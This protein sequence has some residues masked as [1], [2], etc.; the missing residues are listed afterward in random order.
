MHAP[1]SVSENRS[2]VRCRST[3][4][5]AASPGRMSRGVMDAIELMLSASYLLWIELILK[6]WLISN[7]QPR[8]P[9]VAS[10]ATSG[11][12]IAGFMALRRVHHPRL[13]RDVVLAW[14]TI[15]TTGS[16][17]E[18]LPQRLGVLPAVA[19]LTCGLAAPSL[20]MGREKIS[21][22]RRYFYGAALTIGLIALIN[23]PA[24][25]PEKIFRGGIVA[26]VT[27]STGAVAVWL[28]RG[29]DH[30]VCGPVMIPP[31]LVKAGAILLAGGIVLLFLIIMSPL[32]SLS[33]GETAW[34]GL[35][36]GWSDPSILQSGDIIGVISSPFHARRALI[37]MVCSLAIPLLVIRRE[38]VSGSRLALY[39]TAAVIGLAVF[40]SGPAKLLSR[41]M[42]DLLL[43]I[44]KSAQVTSPETLWY[45]LTLVKEQGLLVILVLGSTLITSLGA[46]VV[47]LT[48]SAERPELEARISLCAGAISSL[49]GVLL[50]AH[51]GPPFLTGDSVAGTWALAT[52]IASLGI[53]VRLPDQA[54]DERPLNNGSD[55]KR[56][57]W[58]VRGMVGIG[59]LG[60]ALAVSVVSCRH[61]LDQSI[62]PYVGAAAPPGYQTYVPLSSI[63]REM[64]DATVAFEDP[65]FYHHRGLEWTSLHYALRVNVRAGRVVLGGSTITQQLAKNLFLG[66][67]RTLWRKIKELAFAAEIERLL[68]KQRILELYLNTIDYGMGQHG[69]EAA[70]HYYF[71]KTPGQL[72]LAESAMLVGLVPRPPDQHLSPYQL[73]TGQRTALQRIAYRWPERY[74]EADVTGAAEAPLEPLV[75]LDEEQV[76]GQGTA[77]QPP[78]SERKNAQAYWRRMAV[79]IM[80]MVFV[81]CALTSA[82]AWRAF[83]SEWGGRPPGMPAPRRGRQKT[84]LLTCVAFLSALTIGA[85]HWQ[86][87]NR[88]RAE[89][90]IIYPYTA[91]P[92][93]DDR[94]RDATINCVVLHATAETEGGTSRWFL[95]PTAKVSAHF[96]VSK[97]GQIT[98]LV[99]LEERAWHAG[100]SELDGVPDVNNYSVG[101]EI[102]NR[103][104]GT[105]PY[106]DVQYMAVARIIRQL[107]S[108]YRIPDAR[109]V[110]HAQIAPCRKFDPVG[111]DFARLRMMLN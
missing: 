109:I 19:V 69:V 40:A 104:D 95:D 97:E 31:R 2:P 57:R 23:H 38:R 10:V 29:G 83:G 32:L 39:A 25:E 1:K 99:P 62:Q 88:E 86:K 64:Q 30:T 55:V 101:I 78:P 110:S 12:I 14:A 75:R 42:G 26:L 11:G 53:A 46:G 56:R 6:D 85:T 66:K 102:V 67:E 93:R 28:Y 94:P 108:R 103:D 76:G 41:G 9:Y 84:I 77:G 92:N 47:V 43:S 49:Y 54:T 98:Q 27:L 91:S 13:W 82:L 33:M 70:A 44:A 7:Y 17:A 48:G 16:V 50:A 105:D 37:L 106:P 8:Y 36:L 81:G 79:G 22:R 72:T 3:L 100:V 52:I 68:P 107:R 111:F 20:L 35:G 34:L 96:I 90:T 89:Q 4:F 61:A 18:I 59:T 63:S 80:L 51:I 60:L 5:L 21:K 73:L 58:H 15:L 65:E 45:S 71:H 24:N 74:R 87:A